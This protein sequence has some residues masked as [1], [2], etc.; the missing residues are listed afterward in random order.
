MRWTLPKKDRLHTGS[1]IT[2]RL[3]RW[4]FGLTI[5]LHP[6]Y[7]RCDIPNRQA[8]C[9]LGGKLGFWSVGWYCSPRGQRIRRV[10]FFPIDPQAFS[11]FFE[12]R[13]VLIG[14]FSEWLMPRIGSDSGALPLSSSNK[15][16]TC[17]STYQ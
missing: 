10:S 7:R 8:A 2:H 14:R 12:P 1:I 17:W 4:L 3:I 9:A 15:V 11:S 6:R 5:P 16:V 13:C